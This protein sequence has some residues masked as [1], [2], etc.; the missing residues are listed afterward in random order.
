MPAEYILYP[1]FVMVAL[2]YSVG[3][4]GLIMRVRAVRRDGLNPGYFQYNRGGK[5][6]EYMLRTDQN[7]INLFELPVLFYTALVV[8]YMT[9]LVDVLGLALAWAFVVTRVLHSYVHIRSNAILQR[10]RYFL[11]GMLVL[12][13]LWVELFIQLMLR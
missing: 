10:R 1:L 6:P 5:P 8:A 11:V 2:T 13:L 4:R 7:Y 9:S 3:L 12:G